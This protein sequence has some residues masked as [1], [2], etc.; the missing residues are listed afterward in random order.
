[1]EGDTFSTRDWPSRPFFA[2]DYLASDLEML[3]FESA[4]G[5]QILFEPG[6]GEP[7]PE[8]RTNGGQ[9]EQGGNQHRGGNHV[10]PVR[11]MQAAGAAAI[12]CGAQGTG[13]F[14]ER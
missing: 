5:A 2:L 13:G 3:S 12:G 7:C 9:K 8:R 14:C 11:G 1:L 4:Q 10:F 6:H